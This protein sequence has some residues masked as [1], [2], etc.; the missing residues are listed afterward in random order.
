MSGRSSDRYAGC[1]FD[2]LV[3][4]IDHV[5]DCGGDIT[6][7]DVNPFIDQVSTNSERDA[8]IFETTSG[9]V[10]EGRLEVGRDDL[11]GLDRRCHGP[12]VQRRRTDDPGAW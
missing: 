1:T 3:M 9:A 7:V 10:G 11:A 5:R 12:I 6:F 4:I 8:V 2:Q